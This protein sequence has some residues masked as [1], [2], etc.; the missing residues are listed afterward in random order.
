MAFEFYVDDSGKN[1]PPVFV[2]GG[3]LAEKSA[4]ARF[5][6]EWEK[7]LA[8]SPSLD[9]F[10]MADANRCQG[11]FKGF[12]KSERDEKLRTLASLIDNHIEIGVSVAIPHT[13]YNKIFRGQ[14]MRSMDTPYL[15][16][17]YLIQAAT[18]KY[19]RMAGNS[20]V[21]DLIY[22]RQLDREQDVLGA[23]PTLIEGLASEILER[24]PN[25]PIFADDKQNP[26]LQAADLL[27]WHI[28]RSWKDGRDK[29]PTL[30]AA[31]PILNQMI[32]INEIWLE[33]D[34]KYLFDVGHEK[35]LS[36]N[37]L[38]PHQA[39]V[40]KENFDKLAT[41]VN[42]EVMAQAI[43]F[44]PIQMASFPAIGMEKYLFVRSC[45]ACGNPHLH[46]RSGNKC[47]AEQ[48]A[49]EWE[50]PRHKPK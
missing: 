40:L 36:M 47:L 38:P 31:G 15:L 25:P 23:H 13:H 30:S 48:T 45:A 37:T 26:P 22:D 19:L 7:A 46:K 5:S 29:L 1:D 10:K 24:Y 44:Q 8:A 17:F 14:M 20:D 18:H 27:A 49:V 3:L 33:K 35:I 32:L 6:V 2:L 9:H 16:A 42:L 41:E 43:P 34:L 50:F 21:I 4:W 28:R 12:S 11:V 39:E